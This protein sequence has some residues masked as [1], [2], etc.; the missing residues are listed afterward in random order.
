MTALKNALLAL[1]LL[2]AAACATRDGDG[3]S[4]PEV[5]T[6]GKVVYVLNV[7][8]EQEAWA[9][10]VGTC[11]ARGG[12]AVFNGMVQYQRHEEAPPIIRAFAPQRSTAPSEPCPEGASGKA[13]LASARWYAAPTNPCVTGA[14][15]K[16]TT[17]RRPTL[18]APLA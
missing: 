8:T 1:A 9:A 17:A 7:A 11:R 16:A 13:R 4:R 14:S 3:P 12:N 10:A 15:P 6:E 2:G 18:S 5:V